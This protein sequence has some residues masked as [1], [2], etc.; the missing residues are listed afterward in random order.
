MFGVDGQ[1]AGRQ[2]DGGDL[3]VRGRRAEHDRRDPA[4]DRKPCDDSG[5]SADDELRRAAAEVH[6]VE[7]RAPAVARAEQ[8]RVSVQRW[9]SAGV[10]GLA[11]HHVAVQRCGQVAHLAVERDVQ[12]AEVSGSGGGPSGDEQAVLRPRDRRGLARGEP[13][14]LRFRTSGDL[15]DVHRHAERQVGVLVTGRR[16]RESGAVR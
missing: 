1:L 10:A 8:H 12:Q 2:V 15:D 13:G 3:T 9:W 16:E 5:I 7:L 6:R 11:G 4:A 14:Q